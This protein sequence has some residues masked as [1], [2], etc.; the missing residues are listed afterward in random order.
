MRRIILTAL[1]GV[2]TLALARTTTADSGARCPTTARAS[3]R[4]T[5]A[6]TPWGDPDLQGVWSGTESMGVPLERDPELGTRN[7]L[8]EEE[9]QVRRERLLKSASSDNIEAT[10]F[11]IEPEI[12]ASQSRQASLVVDPSNG[13]RPPRTSVAEARRP[14]RNS[15]SGGPF[16]SVADLGIYD[17]CIAV[18]AV[19]AAQP[20]NGLEIVQA[21]GYVAIR[22]EVIHEA[23]VIP[24]DG[25]PHVGAALTTYAGDSRGRWEGQTL[26]VET[27]NLNGQTSLIGDGPGRPAAQAKIIE[28]YTLIDRDGLWYEA[29]IDDPGTWTRLW[30]VAFPRKRDASYRLYEYACH[31]GNYGV[32]NILRASRAAETLSK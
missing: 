27:T 28:R 7:V 26:V 3:A 31:E 17:R 1:V 25:R 9:L 24:L 22:T 30:T 10:N 21:P 19:P 8:T 13:R 16:D 32:A 20:F 23:R 2:S 15:F 18:A 4:Q 11:G 6:R 12:S 14:A 5:W 29:T